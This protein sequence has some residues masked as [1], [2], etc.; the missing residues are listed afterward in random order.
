M[1]S[2]RSF[3]NSTLVA[4]AG[5]TLRSQQTAAQ[6]PAVEP[7][8]KRLIVDSQVHLWKAST[9]DRPW[10]PGTGARA[11]LP[12]PFT[13]ERVVPMMDDAGVDRVVI[14]PPPMDGD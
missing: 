4:G 13:I 7:A 1:L 2:R 3:L 9:A 8:R 14:V 10:V 12:E 5:L 11:Q 6:A